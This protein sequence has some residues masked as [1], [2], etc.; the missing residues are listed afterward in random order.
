MK[1][2]VLTVILV[3]I[4]IVAIVAVVYSVKKSSQPKTGSGQAKE[5]GTPGAPPV[6]QV[7]PAGPGQEAK[8]GQAAQAGTDVE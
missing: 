3:V 2:N 7:Q 6:G 1:R 5:L 4:I 8:G